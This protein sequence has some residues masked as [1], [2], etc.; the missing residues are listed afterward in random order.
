MV[1]AVLLVSI[2][3]ALAISGTEVEA[4][5]KKCTHQFRPPFLG[6]CICLPEGGP[7]PES[8]ASKND[9]LAEKTAELETTVKA[10][11]PT[12]DSRDQKKCTHQFR[13]PFLGG[14]VCLPEG[15]PCPESKELEDRW[16]NEPNLWPGGSGCQRIALAYA[17][18]K[19]YCSPSGYELPCPYYICPAQP[20][21]WNNTDDYFY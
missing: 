18:T 20:D 19:C 16:S 13:P 9:D 7:C 2:V 17:N 11:F 5:A 1:R 10:L 8:K 15:G 3:I 12:S 4:K 6:G 21:N 14:C